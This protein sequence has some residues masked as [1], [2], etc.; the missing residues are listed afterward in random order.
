MD[1]I[2]RL[3]EPKFWLIGIAAAIAAIHLTLVDRV[4]KEDLF[5][6]SALFWLAAGTLIWDKRQ[7][8]NL[9]SSLPASIAGS[10]LLSLMLIR[11][12][13]L[14]NS[15]LFLCALPLVGLLGLAL[16]A[17]GL[18]GLRQYWRELAIFGFLGIYPILERLLRLISLPVL[19]AKISHM[20]LWYTGTDSR[21]DGVFLHLSGNRSVEV[22]EACSGAQSILQ[23]LSVAV[24]FLLM[25]PLRPL[26]RVICLLV[27]VTIGFSVNAGRVALM[28]LLVK[29]TE[30]FQFWHEGQGSLVFSVISVALFGIFCWFAFLRSP[31]QPPM[32]EV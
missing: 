6:T 19:T 15:N 25:F 28:A 7:D 29:Q 31:K 4:Y 17:S 27:A 18:R 3:K 16:L 2:S 1:S 5:A 11:S 9:Q 26:Q 23:M 10:V 24:L 8:L 32:R 14:P 20:L 21:R 22:Y 12:A 30:I 13:T